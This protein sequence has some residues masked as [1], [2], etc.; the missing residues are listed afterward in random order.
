MESKTKKK[1][2]TAVAGVAM[3]GAAVSLTAGTFSYF[4]NTTDDSASLQAG[5][6]TVGTTLDQ[7]IN[8]HDVAPGD[9]VKVTTITVKND[10]TVKGYLSLD[11]IGKPSDNVLRN[12]VQVRFEGLGS[13]MSLTEA[14]ANGPIHTSTAIGPNGTYSVKLDLR[15]PDSHANQNF[16][17]DK[18]VQA[19]VATTLDSSPQV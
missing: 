14:E 5:H 18:Q 7:D 13:W 16:L 10:G 11:L 4:T 17:Q 12:A 2:A 6:L 9:P 8:F 1:L 3:V 19:T 15:L